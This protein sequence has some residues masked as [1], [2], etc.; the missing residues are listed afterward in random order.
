[1]SAAFIKDTP[2]VDNF[3]E[4]WDGSPEPKKILHLAR[5]FER[6]IE[7]LE[8]VVESL[9]DVIQEQEEYLDT[10]QDSEEC[11]ASRREIRMQLRKLAAVLYAADDE[12]RRFYWEYDDVVPTP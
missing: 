1:M 12:V 11:P 9:S 7:A 3:V 5:M 6:R 10:Q 4:E 2:D 8:A